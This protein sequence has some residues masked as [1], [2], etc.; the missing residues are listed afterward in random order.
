MSETAP[1]K[2]MFRAA[3]R[4]YRCLVPADGFYEWTRLKTGKQPWSWTA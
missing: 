3:F 1:D 2:P 4:K